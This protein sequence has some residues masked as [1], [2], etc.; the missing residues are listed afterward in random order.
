LPHFNRRRLQ[1]PLAPWLTVSVE[2]LEEALLVRAHGE[3]DIGTVELLEAR[4]R[5][6]LDRSS[7]VV[8]DLA[9][10][11]FIDS[12]G[13][14]LLLRSSESATQL[15]RAFFIVRPSAQVSWIVDV[16]G[17]AELMP[18]VSDQSGPQPLAASA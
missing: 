4:L 17:T 7:T 18:L 8:L 10:L 11:S 6:A 16:T 13:L 14:R 5:A 12:C 15:G 2:P 3:L 9:G 1:S